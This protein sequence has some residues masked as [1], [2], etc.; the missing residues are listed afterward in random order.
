MMIQEFNYNVNLLQAVLWQ[1]DEATNLLSLINQKQTWYNTYQSQFWT[2]WYN[3]VF[4]LETANQFGLSVWSYILNVPLYL[5]NPEPTDRPTW[6]FNAYDPSFPT[7]ENSYLNFGLLPSSTTTGGNFYNRIIN[8]S[9]EE[10]RFLLRL[11]YFQLVTNGIVGNINPIGSANFQV[12]AG[13]NSFLNY[14]CASSDI[15]FTGTIFVHDNLDMTMTYFI[16]NDTFPIDLLNAIQ[17]LDIFPRPTGVG[18]EIQIG[19]IEM[20]D[21]SGDLMTDESGN[22]M[23]TE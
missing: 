15:M 10:Q 22:I 4:N 12:V 1:Y 20:V 16:T 8:L 14:L 6:G 21:E 17:I 3:N 9:L 13:I 5:N 18:I 11:R 7:L 19:D 23:I 2:D